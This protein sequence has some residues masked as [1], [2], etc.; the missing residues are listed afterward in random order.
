MLIIGKTVNLLFKGANQHFSQLANSFEANVK[1]DPSDLTSK[2]EEKI[3]LKAVRLLGN[4]QYIPVK[5]CT[6]VFYINCELLSIHFNVYILYVIED[7][8]TSNQLGKTS[9]RMLQPEV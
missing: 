2:A 4:G 1:S 5:N 9:L 7:K 6:K 3:S 8:F